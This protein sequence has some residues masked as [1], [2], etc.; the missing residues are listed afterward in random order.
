MA[1]TKT[2]WIAPEGTF[3]ARFA[4]QN[5]T[6]T[7]VEL[8]PAPV[9]T[10]TPTPFSVEHMNKIEEGIFQ[11]HQ[12]L[13]DMPIGYDVHFNF[14]PSTELLQRWRC[15]PLD[16]RVEPISLYQDLFNYM[17]V[18]NAANATADWWYRTSDPEG[19]YRDVNGAYFRVADKQGLF[20]RASGQNSKYTM[21]SDAPYDG[22]SIGEHFGDAVQSM[23]GDLGWMPG[24]DQANGMFYPYE[25]TM[26][27][28][29]LTASSNHGHVQ[30]LKYHIGRQVRIAGETR[31]AS[32]AYYPCIKY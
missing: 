28:V 10:N 8:I 5:E 15:L 2:N 17:Y 18:G 7:S 25:P 29:D 3:L 21:A 4:K 30:F 27:Y 19:L 22:G 23:Q 1:Y 9:F 12:K 13:D 31:V 20:S 6:S 26:L 24:G 16:G 14:R 11:A 32:I